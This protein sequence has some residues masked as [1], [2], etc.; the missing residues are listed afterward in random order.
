M[1]QEGHG[2]MAKCCSAHGLAG[3]IRGRLL[4]AR[5]LGTLLW[6]TS[7][8]PARAKSTAHTRRTT[9]QHTHVP[10]RTFTLWPSHRHPH[11][12]L[13][14]P[15]QVA[16]PE[17]DGA[18]EPIV[19][20]GRDSNTG[21]SHSLPDRIT[22]LCARAI[23]WATL[24]KKR[25]AEKKLAIT[26][27]SFPPDKGNVGTA[28]YLNVFGSIWRVLKNLQKEGYD[29]G[30]LPPREEDLIQSILTQKEAKFN[31]ADL[32]IAYKM[33]VGWARARARG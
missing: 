22:S 2:K 29:V 16:L 30:Q 11:S 18:M 1:V 24:R 32:A 17:L 28:A 10:T 5:A 7:F 27:F 19:F 31:S 8:P 6:P 14:P 13:L 12:A 23:N 26:V 9:R 33:K 3:R 25:N 20:A 15:K 21:K 4:Q